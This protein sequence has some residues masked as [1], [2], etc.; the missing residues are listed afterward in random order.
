MAATSI[1]GGI[2]HRA[3]MSPILQHVDSTC[4]YRYLEPD[5]IAFRCLSWTPYSSL[6]TESDPSVSLT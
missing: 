5:K 2:W 1:Q 6:Y 4:L 3:T